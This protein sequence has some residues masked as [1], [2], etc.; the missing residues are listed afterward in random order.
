MYAYSLAHP[1]TRSNNKEEWGQ[2]PKGWSGVGSHLRLLLLADME[3]ARGAAADDPHTTPRRI[4]RNYQLLED[5]GQI[6]S[7]LKMSMKLK[8]RS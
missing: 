5:L 7:P 6:N 3:A 2:L 1:T 4:R 8:K